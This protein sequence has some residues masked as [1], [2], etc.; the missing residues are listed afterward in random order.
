MPVSAVSNDYGPK[1]KVSVIIPARNEETTISKCLSAVVAQ[2]YPADLVE[3]IVVDDHST[4]KTKEVAKKT[5]SQLKTSSKIISNKENDAGKKSAI[6]EGIRNSS[7]ELLVITDADSV[8]NTKWLSAIENEYQ[9]SGV[10]MLCGPVQIINGTGFLGAFQSLEL[11]GLSLLSGAG[12]RAGIPLL[13]NGSN[14]AYTRKVFDEVQGFNGI[15]T[16]PSGDDILLMFKVHKE[17]PDKIAYLKSKDTIVSTLAQPT[18]E[19]FISQRIRWASKGL[20]SGNRLNSLVSLLVFSANFLSLVAILYII[21][22]GKPFFLLMCGIATKIMADFL[23][24]LFATD[25]FGKKKLLW[26]FPF[27]ELFTMLY[28]TW[29]GI[30]ASFSSYDWK[31]RRYKHAV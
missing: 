7:G 23:L 3:V 25:F 31:G 4:D 1:T 10:Y 9:K 13:C 18:L 14:M 29:V 30:V 26:L 21:A 8:S 16:N 6:T 19:A 22:Y 5:L 17:Y 11:C 24:L 27:A 20:S 12:I 15:D 2:V 28:I